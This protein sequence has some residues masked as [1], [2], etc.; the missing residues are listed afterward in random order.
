MANLSSAN[1]R[2]TKRNILISLGAVAFFL[3]GFAVLY[4]ITGGGV[5]ALALIP[6]VVS[7]WLMGWKGGI[8]IGI[9][10]NILLLPVTAIVQAEVSILSYTFSSLVVIPFGGVVGLISEKLTEASE[11]SKLL[12]QEQEQLQ[13]EIVG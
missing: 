13:Q 11:L 6:L 5:N 10:T 12:K 7:G 1:S 8:F 9:L 3:I 4:P 2:F